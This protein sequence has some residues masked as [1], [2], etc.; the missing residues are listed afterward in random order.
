IVPGFTLV[1]MGDESGSVPDVL[2]AANRDDG[3]MIEN[4]TD[5]T[6]PSPNDPSRESD[7]PKWTF[8][9]SADGGIGGV[10]QSVSVATGTDVS[11][12]RLSMIGA[13]LWGPGL[14]LYLALVLAV[15]RADSSNAPR[16]RRAPEETARWM[17]IAMAIGG[18]TGAASV[19]GGIGWG[20]WP[21]GSFY[22]D[23]GGFGLMLLAI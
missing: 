13:A 9:R 6:A 10:C 18:I 17:R 12:V 3:S 2:E 14:L 19:I 8:V 21:V 4:V 23:G 16:V 20:G 7:P 11:L 5:S 22:R 1:P 15:P